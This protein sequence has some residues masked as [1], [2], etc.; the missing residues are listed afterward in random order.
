MR[1]RIMACSVA[2]LC[3][4][5]GAGADASDGRLEINQAC[6][7]AGCFAGD[8]PGFPVQASSDQSYVLTSNLVVADVNTSAIQG[9]GGATIDLNGFSV[10]GPVTCTR[11][12]FYDP[13]TITCTAFGGGNGVSVGGGSVVRNGRI[14]GFGNYGILANGGLSSHAIVEDVR[15]EQNNAGGIYLSNGSVRR[16]TVTLNGGPGI[17]NVPGGDANGAITVDDCNVAF[18][19]GHGINLAG[20]IHNCRIG[21][22]GGA[23]VT[24][25][26]AGGK[27]SSITNCQIYR[28]TGKGI[29][30]YGS[31]RDSEIIGNENA[32]G[33]VIGSMSDEGGNNV[34]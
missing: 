20:L 28:N 4:V 22:N 30:A 18:N 31:Y 26:N 32:G 23:G 14:H 6:V 1:S 27:D 15:V 12:D 7:A 10:S 5:F 25:N 21:Y 11:S 24:H 3:A 17:W 19:K 29:D 9:G 34:H 2:L 33:Q 13:T 16:V 8:S